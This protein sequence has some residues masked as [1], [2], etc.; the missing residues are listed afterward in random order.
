M[1]QGTQ[2]SAQQLALVLRRAAELERKRKG[3][4]A[5]TP[6]SAL[7][8]QELREIV[9]EVGLPAEDVE[10]AL[11]EL[12]VGALAEG[13]ASPSFLDRFVGPD[14]LVVER[15]VRGD[16]AETLRFVDEFMASQAHE[17]K[18]D[19][20]D[21]KIWGPAPGLIAGARRLLDFAGKI[22][23]P[24]DVVVEAQVVP[25]PGEAGKVLVRLTLR[26]G[27]IRSRRVGRIVGALVTGAA[28]GVAGVLAASGAAELIT[29]G[30][31]AGV[32]GAG[33][34]KVRSGYRRT[35]EGATLGLQRFLDRLEHG[36]L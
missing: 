14:V 29:I 10:R 16:V 35:V 12:R 28:I 15:V 26:T 25:A 19:L 27:E 20:G 3:D 21:R 2:L 34:A 24:R 1:T 32:A 30:A 36:G 17:V 11:A 6:G 5:P 9:A 31:G 4:D 33:Y 23:I 7:S 13:A 22:S 8:E 18:R